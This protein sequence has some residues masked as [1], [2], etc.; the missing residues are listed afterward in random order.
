MSLEKAVRAILIA[1]GT[2][3]GLVA[4]RIYPQRRPMGTALPAI[5]YM[6]VF[7]HENE[8]LESQSGIRRARMSIEVMSATYGG[9]KTLRDAVE[10][11]LINYTGTISGAT[12]NSVRLESSVD[13]D[14]INTPASE[15]GT[16]R[17]IMD[18]I[19]WYE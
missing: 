9:N 10:A 17:T 15:F 7:S 14:E 2:T 19:I 18:F 13:I 6:N 12:I 4:S 3:T 1:D 8:A 16:F 11:A 5:V